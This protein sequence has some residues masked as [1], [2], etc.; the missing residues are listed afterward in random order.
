MSRQPGASSRAWRVAARAPSPSATSP[1]LIAAGPLPNPNRGRSAALAKAPP[2]IGKA[3]PQ[4]LKAF[5]QPGARV[6]R[7]LAQVVIAMVIKQD[8]FP[9]LGHGRVSTIKD[10]PCFHGE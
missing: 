9:G 8:F 3:A 2:G 1:P 6:A 10:A 7:P 4:G 5:G